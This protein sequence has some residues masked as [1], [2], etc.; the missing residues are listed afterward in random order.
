MQPGHTESEQHERIRLAAYYLWQKRGCPFGM[1]EAD[2]FQAEG[3]MR[4]EDE[5]NTPKPA[6]VAVAEVMGSAL[7]SVAGLVA[8][9]GGLVHA[10]GIAE[11][12]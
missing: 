5:E 10:N 9:V 8:S 4:A 12:E 1:P 6:L 11:S 3:Q 7:G 2:W